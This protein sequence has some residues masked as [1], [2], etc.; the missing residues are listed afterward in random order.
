M[1]WEAIHFIS[2]WWKIWLVFCRDENFAFKLNVFWILQMQSRKRG[3]INVDIE[4][5][6]IVTIL[7]LDEWIWKVVLR[8]KLVGPI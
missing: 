1:D 8:T 7:I 6:D 2:K 3:I 5:M 4:K